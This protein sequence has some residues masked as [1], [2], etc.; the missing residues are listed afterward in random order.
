MSTKIDFK[1]YPI[2]LI[3]STLLK[4]RTTGKNII[5]ATEQYKRTLPGI[6]EKSE[7]TEDLLNA[8]DVPFIQP[9]VTKH[10]KNKSNEPSE[11]LKFYAIMAL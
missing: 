7:I 9:R 10:W 5:F 4:D 3:L 11:R 1:S 6:S 8:S 2:N